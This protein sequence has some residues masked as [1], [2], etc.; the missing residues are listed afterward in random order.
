MWAPAEPD[1]S[2]R[3]PGTQSCATRSM[4]R[5]AHD[6]PSIQCT[7]P[8]Q[9]PP[10]TPTGGRQPRDRAAAGVRRGRPRHH[11][12]RTA[13]VE[14]KRLRPLLGHRAAACRGAARRAA[15]RWPCSRS[16]RAPTPTRRR[17]AFWAVQRALHAAMPQ[18][19]DDLNAI[20]AQA[21]PLMPAALQPRRLEVPSAGGAVGG[22][23]S[24]RPRFARALV[25]PGPRPLTG[26]RAEPGPVPR[27]SGRR[28]DGGVARSVVP[29]RWRDGENP[30]CTRS[31]PVPDE[32]NI[33]R[34]SPSSK[35]T[36]A[37]LST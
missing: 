12:R 9:Q 36:Y 14:A 23:R 5:V 33:S 26:N 21:V 20:G 22:A 37:R 11:E 2:S 13:G 19:R 4:K 16:R 6:K 27:S 31:S 32:Q 24:A 17:L 28:S 10:R 35:G 30:E 25:R 29:T 8:A 18:Y 3:H 15:A 1:A 34:N 7:G